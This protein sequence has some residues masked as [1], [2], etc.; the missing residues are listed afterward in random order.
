MVII[1]WRTC[2]IFKRPLTN[3][4]TSGVGKARLCSV[5][6]V[7]KMDFWRA[8]CRPRKKKVS[9]GG[10][11]FNNLTYYRVI[12]WLKYKLKR[13]NSKFMERLSQLKIFDVESKCRKF[14]ERNNYHV[15]LKKILK[16]KFKINK[17]GK[18]FYQERGVN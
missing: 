6:V 9:C 13:V 5:P 15:N 10:I 2:Q 7:L 8:F 1:R 18:K 17:K 14:E 12:M 11:E 3:A 4:W 16:E